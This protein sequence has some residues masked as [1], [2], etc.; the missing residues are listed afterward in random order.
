MN[1]NLSGVNS[2]VVPFSLTRTYLSSSKGRKNW[3]APEEIGPVELD[4]IVTSNCFLI[5]R[6]ASVK[7]T[8]AIFCFGR[9]VYKVL[10][11]DNCCFVTSILKSFGLIFDVG[12]PPSQIPITVVTPIIDS[13]FWETPCIFA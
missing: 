9:Y 4:V 5:I 2:S 12:S 3:F 7:S 6:S 1:E 10:S 11:E 13:A 8:D